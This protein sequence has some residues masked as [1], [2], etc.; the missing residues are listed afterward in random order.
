M[1]IPRMPLTQAGISWVYFLASIAFFIAPF[2]L[3][4]NALAADACVV[5]AAQVVS[6][7]GVVE[8]RR[9]QS[10]TWEPAALETQL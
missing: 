6:V 8:V 4:R 1:T 10:T 2:V 9:H 7:Q 3:M 5:R